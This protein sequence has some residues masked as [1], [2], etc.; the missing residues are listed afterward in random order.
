MGRSL[1][2]SEA[3]AV[4]VA[5]GLARPKRGILASEQKPRGP[6]PP[7]IASPVTPY[8]F[9]IAV[10]YPST[11]SAA[12]HF[13]WLLN[14]AS[15]KTVALCSVCAASRSAARAASSRTTA[16]CPSLAARI[17]GVK[18]YLFASGRSAPRSSAQQPHLL[19][20]AATRGGHLDQCGALNSKDVPA[21]GARAR[22]TRASGSMPAC[23]SRAS[24]RHRNAIASHFRKAGYVDA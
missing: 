10:L 11:T 22:A 5:N 20:L 17:S 4:D 9:L 7:P 8:L 12:T 15:W 21:E 3:T 13:R 6:P 2:I 18:P 1:E 23:S 14:H 24:K 16:T 19:Q